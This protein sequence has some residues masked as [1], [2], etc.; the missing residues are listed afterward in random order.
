MLLAA[1]QPQ[2]LP[3]LGYFDKMDQA[4]LFVLLDDVQFKKNECQNRNRIP[5][6]GEWQY[7]T[8]PVRHKFPQ[9]IQEVVIADQKWQKSHLR[10]LEQTYSKCDGLE[11]E[12]PLLEVLYTR[13]WQQLTKLNT[14]CIELIGSRFRIDTE[15]VFSSDHP[16]L[17]DHPDLRLIELCQR[18]KADRYLAASGGREYINLQLWEQAGIQVIFQDFEHPVYSQGKGNFISGM[19]ALDLLLRHGPGSFA[20]IRE[21]RKKAA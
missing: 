18:Y 15:V 12:R 5:S 20:Q 9:T 11:A 19:C 1:H 2:Y 21:R 6:G 16:D 13:T 14:A 8:V 7:L 10:T 17:A 3:W 4:D